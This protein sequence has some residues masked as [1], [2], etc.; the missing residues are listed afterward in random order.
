M[1][2][3]D[4]IWFV[5][6]CGLS[7]CLLYAICVMKYVLE[8][9]VRAPFD[10]FLN[11]LF[12]DC[13]LIRCT[14]YCSSKKFLRQMKM[15]FISSL[16]YIRTLLRSEWEWG[17]ITDK[18]IAW[19]V[20]SINFM[21]SQLYRLKRLSFDPVLC[22]FF[23]CVLIFG[24]IL[25]FG[26]NSGSARACVPYTISFLMF[27]NWLHRPCFRNAWCRRTKFGWNL[28]KQNQRNHQKT[29]ANGDT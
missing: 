28:T 17:G 16:K 10:L 25:F 12:L 22:F 20:A 2:M 24:I 18:N 8:I 23:L 3:Y 14:D 29:S 7:S 13:V 5:V 9:A 4:I 19:N 26:A 27:G 21:F 15:I 6:R 11:H 1:I